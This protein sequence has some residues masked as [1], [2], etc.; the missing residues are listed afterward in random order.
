MHW[1][2]LITVVASS[3]ERGRCRYCGAPI[4]WATTTS[5]PGHP[6]KSLP[7]SVPRPFPLSVTRNDETGVVFEHWP[8]AALHF[9]SCP[10]RP[11]QTSTKA[12]RTHA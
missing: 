1:S 9:R 3:L 5:S 7:F 6:A 4:L 11:K 10:D 8:K 2:R 12:R